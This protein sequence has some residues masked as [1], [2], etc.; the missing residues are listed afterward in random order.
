MPSWGYWGIVWEN[1]IADEGRHAENRL[2]AIWEIWAMY[3]RWYNVF[4][5]EA[6]G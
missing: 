2:D 6:T 4:T 5:C 3:P 1:H